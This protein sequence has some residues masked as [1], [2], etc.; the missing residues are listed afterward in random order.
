MNRPMRNRDKEVTDAKWMEEIL[1]RGQVIFLGLAAPDGRPYVAPMGYGYDGGA[2]YIHGARGG[3]K[4][5]LIAE[6]PRVAFNVSLDVELVSAETGSNFSMRYR[7]VSGYGRSRELMERDEKNRALRILMSQYNGPHTDLTE[8]NKDSVWV[9]RI[10][11]EHM[12]GKISGYPRP[13]GN[14]APCP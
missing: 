9:V 10:D 1:R 2:L 14:G 13:S 6:N 3:L 11:I 12:S 5:E 4:N 8:G 7:S